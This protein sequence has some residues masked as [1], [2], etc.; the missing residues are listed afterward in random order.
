MIAQSIDAEQRQAIDASLDTCVAIMGAPGSGKS[1]ALAL[2]LDRIVRERGADSAFV[3]THP[4]D[5]VKLALI[6]LTMSGIEVAT[7][8]DVEAQAIFAEA[9]KGLFAL[10]WDDLVAG[11]IDPEVPGLRS[12]DRF[13]LAAFRLFRKLRCAAIEPA[14]FLSRSLRGATDFY[15]N[16]NNAPNFANPELIRAT[17]DVYRDSLSVTPSELTRQYRREV[18]LAKI[19]AQLYKAYVTILDERNVATARDSIV[20]ARSAITANPA[21]G[22]L[23]RTRFPLLCVDDAQ[24]L[25]PASFELLTAVYGADLSGVTFAGDP[26]SA[27][28]SFH[29][30]SPKRAFA[31]ANARTTLTVQH[32][33]PLALELACRRLCN[34][35]GP[36]DAAGVAPALIL[37]RAKGQRDEAA[38]V[39]D[40]VRAALDSGTAADDIALV[41]RSVSDVHIYEEALLDRGVAVAVG[42]DLNIFKEP[43]VLD[44]LALLWNLWDPFKHDWMLRT[45][46]GH[47]FALSDSSLA[48]L[49]SEPP[50]TQTAL[51]PFDAENAPTAR[52]SRWD[53]K[54]DLRLGW[55]VVRGEQDAALT[56][57]ARERVRRFR[58]MREAWIGEMGRLPFRVLARRI[59]ADALAP[60]GIADSARA[61]SQRLLLQQLLDRLG[62]YAEAHPEASLGDI[63]EYA[64]LRAQSDLE[65]CEGWSG[66]GFVKILSI[67]A[68][69]GRSFAFVAVPDARAG[70]F[71]RWYVPDSFLFSPKYGMVPKENVGDARAARTAKFTYYIETEKTRDRYNAEERR[72]FIY[73]LRRSTR[74][75]VV[76]AYGKATLGK[77]A[78]EFLAELTKAHLPGSTVID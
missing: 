24:D 48:T 76:S 28:N 36:T 60:A 9:A 78:P 37:H 30:A 77:T 74:E 63:L 20:R 51:F 21:L 25:T 1:T 62:A 57:I 31:A 70:S 73:A 16:A 10:E 15:A 65:G 18:D 27:T 42:G 38:F 43:R 14:Q 8:D 71:P 33:S 17:K 11:R 56:T 52:S 72:A 69:R 29:G 3:A 55:N 53:P 49:C 7:I 41:F 75:V 47:A 5:L 44:A 61:R 22:E 19:L 59:W 50:D 68:V 46:G 2:R 67:D 66:E 12:P 32:R 34:D 64:R 39:A 54:R 6:V 4:D 13:L 40:R 23:L 45:L 35:L 58:A 26:G